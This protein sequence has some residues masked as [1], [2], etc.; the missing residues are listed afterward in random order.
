MLS[1]SFARGDD[2]VGIGEQSVEEAPRVFAIGSGNPDV[3]GVFAAI[4]SEPE[5]GEA[6]ANEL[7]ILHVVLNGCLHLLLS[8]L[9]IN[10][11]GSAL[12]NVGGTVELAALATVPEGI[13]RS[14][15]STFQ[16]FRDDRVAT[17][18]ARKS[19]CFG[20]TAELDGTFLRPFYLVD[21][22]GQRVVLDEGF[23][24]GIIKNECLLP[25]GIIDPLCQFLLR[26]DSPRGVVGIAEIDDVEMLRWNIARKAVPHM[27]GD[28]LEG[29][30]CHDV[31]VHINRIDGVGDA[32]DVVGRENVAD[33]A[34]VAL[35]TIADEYFFAVKLNAPRKE[36]MLDDGVDEEVITMFWAIASKSS[37]VGTFI[38]SAVHG[39]DGSI[40]QRTG[41]IADAEADNFFLRMCRGVCLHFLRNVR[42]QI[43][44]FDF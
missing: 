28:V 16:F 24:G 39:L 43:T 44:A 36:I 21:G 14:A 1:K 2:H 19:C 38:H 41:D 32:H 17:P 30:S 10:G 18:N 26:D 23:V 3:G 35:G 9:R 34:R 25:E 13:E 15:V 31:R 11:F 40:G 5:E 42:E 37:S 20:E 4:D 22:V 33:V 8:F 7:G 29:A 12:R 6:F 27:A